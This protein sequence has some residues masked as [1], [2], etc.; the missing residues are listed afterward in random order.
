MVGHERFVV[1]NLSALERFLPSDFVVRD[2]G[3]VP[4]AGADLFCANLAL[5]LECLDVVC[6]ALSVIPDEN[7]TWSP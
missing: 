2:E 3:P 1:S 7:S 6:N 5:I 4:V